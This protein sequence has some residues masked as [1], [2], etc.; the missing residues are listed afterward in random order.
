MAVRWDYLPR[1]P[2]DLVDRPSVPKRDLLA[3]GAADLKNLVAVAI[4]SAQRTTISKI[5]A[6]ADHRWAVLWA[7]AIYTGLRESELL[8]LQ[9][10][11]IDMG[12]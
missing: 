1:N 8:A 6:R 7:L 5:Q 3:L 4:G 12:T 11:D 2:A 10:P 9:W